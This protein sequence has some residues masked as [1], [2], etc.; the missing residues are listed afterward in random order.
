MINVLTN[1][2]GDDKIRYKLVFEDYKKEQDQSQTDKI[3]IYN[4][5][6]ENK[7]ILRLIDSPGFIDTKGKEKDEEYIE[8]FKN[9]FRNEIFY[10]N[11]ICFVINCASYR[12]NEIQKELYDKVSSL[13]SEEIKNN[14][15]FIFTHY[16]SS[17][18][19]DAKVSLKNDDVFKDI[20]NANNIF[21]LDNAWAFSGDKNIKNY[22]WEKTSGEIK[23]LINDKFVK[24]NPVKT[25]QSAEIIEKRKEYHELFN[26]KMIDFKNKVKEIKDLLEK[27]KLKELDKIKKKRALKVTKNFIQ[28][29]EMK[30]TNC[31]KCERTC[32][33]FC[34]CNPFMGI[35][36]FCRIFNFFGFCKFCNCYFSR[37][38]RVNSIFIEKEEIINF[39]D[40]EDEEKYIKKEV[41]KVETNFEE[42]YLDLNQI[43][44]DILKD[45]EIN[46]KKS[47]QDF[48]GTKS[49]D[50]GSSF[51]KLINYKK[52]EAIQMVLNIHN[53]L[54]TLNR[55][56]LNKT[57]SK[58]MENFFDEI[59]QLD[60]F[61]NEIDIIEKIKT[62]YL[63]VNKNEEKNNI[64]F[65]ILRDEDNISHSIEMRLNSDF[66]LSEYEYE[67]LIKF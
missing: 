32:H 57:I 51:E 41:E 29:S 5:K 53:Y 4:V 60:D 50:E 26:E 6:I 65:L 9:F 38:S 43:D 11:C 27:Q 42:S 24:L 8:N 19:M 63:K 20:I 16:T 25:A 15:V 62:E 17:G 39:K 35:R 47:F 67:D 33:K 45:N 30:N 2:K 7:K 54:E 31:N 64:K 10:L 40:D 48:Y 61:K 36:Y 46:I 12:L 44:I 66:L 21:K 56:A 18:D 37:H 58:N 55:L 13:F 59:K 34:D 3:N 28:P 23:R 14:F 1:I 49:M 22:M 52:I